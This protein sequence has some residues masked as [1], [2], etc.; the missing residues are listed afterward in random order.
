MTLTRIEKGDP[1]AYLG[2]YAAVLFSLAMI[3]RLAGVA[4]PRD[5]AWGR[6]LEEEHPPRRIRLPR[7]KPGKAGT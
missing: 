2:N 3:D 7:R 5:D 4:H 6:E 1:G